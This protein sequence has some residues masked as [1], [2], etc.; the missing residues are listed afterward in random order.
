MADDWIEFRIEGLRELE[1]KLEDLPKKVAQKVIRE[2]VREGAKIVRD[3]FVATAPPPPA[4]QDGARRADA[5]GSGKTTLG[6]LREKASWRIRYR[7][8]AD[9]YAGSAY[10]GPSSK[11]LE[12]R[13][14]GKTKGL[15]R[16]AA[17]IVKMLETG[18]RI[19]YPFMTA[20]WE[21]VKMRVL[22][23]IIEKIREAL[24]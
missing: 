17:F 11:I 12:T 4:Y 15:P 2:G 14:R 5:K 6:H 24:E 3:T 7:G 22:D 8:R 9:D 19:R 16:T 10:V 23:R 18:R 13:T 21:S 20:A 1:K